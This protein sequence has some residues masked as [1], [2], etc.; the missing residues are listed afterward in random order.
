MARLK[1]YDDGHRLAAWDAPA[2]VTLSTAPA[3]ATA[4]VARVE[5]DASGRYQLGPWR[6]LGATPLPPL[7]LPRGSYVFELALADH[8]PTRYPLLVDRG[9]AFTATV[10]LVRAAAVPPGMIYVPAGR[11]LI[12]STAP[13]AQRREFEK[14]PPLHPTEV[15]AALVARTEVTIGDWVEYVR[16]LPP[17]EQPGRLPSSSVVGLS[18]EVRWQATAGGFD[19]TLQPA[20]TRY[21]VTTDGELVYPMRKE[22]QRHPVRA[23]PVTGVRPADF[24]AYAAW[25]AATG[26]VPGA[27][28]CDER[29]WEHAVRGADGR[30]YAAGDA[31][32]PTDANFGEEGSDF[33]G[34]GPDAV[35]THPGGV[36]PFGIEDS[37]GNA[38]E[39][40]TSAFRGTDFVVRGGGYLLDGAAATAT[41]RDPIDAT[42]HDLVVGSRICA[43]AGF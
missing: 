33:A 41:L 12:G 32:A 18:G 14:A 34:Y 26:R 42:V 3:G 39:I 30:R 40:A 43:S 28:V 29:T 22:R 19:I 10:P 23:L 2:T 9:E 7:S 36:S 13:E 38:W 21:Q 24:A 8:A 5:P 16:S 4:R 1:L 11:F 27:R 35:G 31:L 6:D 17:A 25:L 37:A 15:P 20:S